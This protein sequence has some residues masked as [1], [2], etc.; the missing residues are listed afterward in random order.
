VAI[1]KGLV[2]LDFTIVHLVVFLAASL[3]E[4][5]ALGH[6]LVGHMQHI[7]P[8]PPSTSIIRLNR[9]IDPSRTTIRDDCSTSV[10][11]D[12]HELHY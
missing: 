12:W 1:F 10:A 9:V 7:I 3:K 6:D 11:L 8:V 2:H 5:H 4:V